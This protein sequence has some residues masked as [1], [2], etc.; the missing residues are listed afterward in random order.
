LYNE[1]VTKVVYSPILINAYV[2]YNPPEEFSNNFGMDMVYSIEVY[3]HVHEAD[4]R[5]VRVREGDFVK[6]GDI[7]YEIKKVTEPQITFGQINEKVM[8]KLECVVSRE[9]NFTIKEE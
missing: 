2:L 3:I 6:F 7:I 4:E 8:Y 1:A 9:S 5:N